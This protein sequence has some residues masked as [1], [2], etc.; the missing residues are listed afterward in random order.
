MLEIASVKTPPRLADLG[1]LSPPVCV[2]SVFAEHVSFHDIAGIKGGGE[3]RAV[4][5]AGSVA[6]MLCVHFKEKTG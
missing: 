1:W 6:G 2:I 3:S 5:S 4:D